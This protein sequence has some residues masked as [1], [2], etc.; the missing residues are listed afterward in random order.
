VTPILQNDI[1]YLTP[2]L[3]NKPVLAAGVDPS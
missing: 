2:S 3:F 1:E